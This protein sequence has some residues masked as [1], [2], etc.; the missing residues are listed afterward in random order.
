MLVQGT[1]ESGQL[2]T[3]QIQPTL[4]DEINEAQKEDP[5]YGIQSS[6]R[7]WTKD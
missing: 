5:R 7:S 2:M 1:G 3:F 4:M 6:S